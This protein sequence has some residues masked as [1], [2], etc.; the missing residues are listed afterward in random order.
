MNSHCGVDLE[1]HSQLGKLYNLFLTT[2]TICS[3]Q[4]LSA[5]L[6][7]PF[8]VLGLSKCL[9]VYIAGGISFADTGAAN[10]ATHLPPVQARP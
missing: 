4:N 1:A 5:L 10:S 3:R 7:Y 6:R 9:M 2:F 8:L